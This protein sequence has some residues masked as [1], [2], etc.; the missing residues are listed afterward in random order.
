MNSPLNPRANVQQ[1]QQQSAAQ[2]TARLLSV[3]G[4]NDFDIDGHAS[5][6]RVTLGHRMSKG[7]GFNVYHRSGA[8]EG[9]AWQ[10]SLRKS[11]EA[12]LG[13]SQLN[14]VVG[15]AGVTHVD[16]KGFFWLQHSVPGSREGLWHRFCP[17]NGWT[18]SDDK[19]WIAKLRPLPP[20]PFS[21]GALIHWAG[22][23]NLALVDNSKGV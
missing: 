18:A 23:D 9:A 14:L 5:I 16:P 21:P 19:R 4:F 3:F 12:L 11:L 7:D 6:K 8:K 17:I 10:G 22:P 1:G 15:S 13:T 2:I 20:N